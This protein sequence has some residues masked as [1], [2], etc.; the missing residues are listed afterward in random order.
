MAVFITKARISMARTRG[1]SIPLPILFIPIRSKLARNRLVSTKITKPIDKSKRM[2]IIDLNNPV[3][4][5]KNFIKSFIS[6]PLYP[7]YHKIRIVYIL[8]NCIV[9]ISK[10]QDSKLYKERFFKIYFQRFSFLVFM[11]FE[12]NKFLLKNYYKY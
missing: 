6:P 8:N 7:L 3:I 4:M 12:R 5:L 9:K 11:G 10:K 2:L 1:F